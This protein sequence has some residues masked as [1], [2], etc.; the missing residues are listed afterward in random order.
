MKDQLD[1]CDIAAPQRARGRLLIEADVTSTGAYRCARL[2]QEGSFR[3]LFPRSGTTGVEAVI[4]NTA[5][6]ITGG[7][8]F[9]V[10]GVAQNDAQLTITT[11]A[12]ERIYRAKDDQPGRLTTSLTIGSNARLNWM[13]Q[14]TILFDGCALSRR[15][16]IDVTDTSTF[17]MVEPVVFGRIASGE[18]V[19]SGLFDD[20]II[21]RRDG[22]PIY[23]DGCQMTGNM[24]R[25]LNK[26]AIG[27]GSAAMANI[28]FYGQNATAL[29]DPV[30]AL[31]P[32]TAG[33]SLL[34]DDL[35]VIRSLAP[36]S[37]TLRKTLLPV[38]SHLNNNTLP[39]NW[40][41]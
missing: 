16:Q 18:T 6:G 12:A 20:R 17:L 3:A 31:L 2:R 39:K 37:F 34:H 28:V 30:R 4:L 7:D 35:L 8:D 36:D 1:N 22:I 38:I 15:L 41:L 10:D 40:R 27:R 25:M 13:P 32:D 24:S 14:E 33:A 29:L 9:C 26:P 21:M 5:G 23:Q 11:Q 19:A